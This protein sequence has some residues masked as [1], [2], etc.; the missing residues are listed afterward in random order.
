MRLTATTATFV[1]LLFLALACHS[2]HAGRFWS[3]GQFK[4]WSS[5]TK[6]WIRVDDSWSLK[7]IV[8]GA[9]DT[10][11]WE[12]SAFSPFPRSGYP[13]TELVRYN[14]LFGFKSNHQHANSAGSWCVPRNITGDVH[15]WAPNTLLCNGGEGD[16]LY[17]LYRYKFIKPS[18]FTGGDVIE[19]GYPVH[20]YDIQLSKY[21]SNWIW[22]SNNAA[23]L[24]DAATPSSSGQRFN[25]HWAY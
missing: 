17:D 3:D 9:D 10:D 2:V 25:F 4:L 22:P 24:C 16:A 19:D 5:H 1:A 13:L 20:I 23:L 8:R 18:G 12:A 15:T 6:E 11:K 14:E 21:C 7:E